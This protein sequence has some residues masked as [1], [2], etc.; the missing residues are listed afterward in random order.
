MSNIPRNLIIKNFACPTCGAQKRQNCFSVG[1][2]GG[3]SKRKKVHL[4]RAQLAQK[5]VAE[6][7][8]KAG[9]VNHIVGAKV[10]PKPKKRAPKPEVAK[11]GAQSG[12][13]FYSSWEWKKLRFE[14]LKLHGHRCQCCGWTPNDTSH[15]WLVVDHI[16]PRSKFPKLSLEL[17]NL[18]ILCNDCNM[19]KSNVH[20]DDFRADVEA[21]RN[22]IQF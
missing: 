8:P 9:P 5:Y 22:M 6:R 2:K 3:V 7:A 1:P 16:K 4:G 10:K 17:S 14:A 20:L 21:Y 18:Q 15:G 19:G 11:N 13:G 12:D